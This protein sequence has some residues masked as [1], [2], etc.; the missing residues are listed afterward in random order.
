MI[1]IDTN[2]L[3]HQKKILFLYKQGLFSKQFWKALWEKYTLEKSKAPKE[4]CNSQKAFEKISSQFSFNTENLKCVVSTLL[5]SRKVERWNITFSYKASL[6]FFQDGKVFETLH[7]FSFELR[8]IVFLVYL[9]NLSGSTSISYF[10]KWK[11]LPL[12]KI[13]LCK[14]AYL[15][16]LDTHNYS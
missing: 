6:V 3:R 11:F 2:P 15:P 13:L 14:K 8:K 7:M 10:I 16:L 12:N 5:I 1:Q 4:K 9:E